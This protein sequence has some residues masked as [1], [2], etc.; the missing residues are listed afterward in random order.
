MNQLQVPGTTAQ[1]PINKDLQSIGTPGNGSD[2]NFRSSTEILGPSEN[3]PKNQVQLP[4]I[5]DE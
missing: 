5:N 1:S 2:G 3:H 4:L